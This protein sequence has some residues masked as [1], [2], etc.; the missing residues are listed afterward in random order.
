MFEQGLW[1]TFFEAL[2]RYVKG[3]GKRHFR[4]NLTPHSAA[5]R[6]MPGVD[7]QDRDSLYDIMDGLR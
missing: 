2:R 1:K 4:L 6:L 3:T 7:L 5:G